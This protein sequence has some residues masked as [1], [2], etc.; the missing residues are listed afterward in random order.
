M[1][2]KR[3]KRAR[4]SKNNLLVNEA[5]EFFWFWCLC[6]RRR[7]KVARTCRRLDTSRVNISTLK[8]RTENLCASSTRE[9]LLLDKSDVS[10]LATFC[11][12][13]SRLKAMFLTTSNKV[14]FIILLCCC[15]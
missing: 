6:R 7:Q 2:W 5:S 12:P 13:L 4:R 3:R 10:P 14:L 15:A 11:E 9:T 1:K 8:V